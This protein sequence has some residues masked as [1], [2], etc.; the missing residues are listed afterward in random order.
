MIEQNVAQ[1][2]HLVEI[3]NSTSELEL[4]APAPLN[5]VCFRYKPS[6]FPEG[7]LD[8]LNKEILFQL[9]EQGI[10]APSSTVL[11]GKF[12]IRVAICNHRSRLED[13][14]VL[15]NEV[16]RLG[17]ELAGSDAFKIACEIWAE[18]D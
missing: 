13:F 9:Q 6:D 4:M 10:A 11:D 7:E 3:I 16:C 14:E 5:I 2:R 15:A 12:A 18:S 8:G 17:K 1:A